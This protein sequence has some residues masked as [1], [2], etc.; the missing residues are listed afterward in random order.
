[1]VASQPRSDVVAEVDKQPGRPLRLAVPPGRYLVRKRA[2]ASTGQLEV[3]LPYG[4]ERPVPLR[5]SD[6]S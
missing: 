5:V 3:E 4:G 1:M 6:D 2:G